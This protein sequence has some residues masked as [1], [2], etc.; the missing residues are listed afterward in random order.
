MEAW[1]RHN[2][3]RR[4]AEQRL[5]LQTAL[6]NTL[7]CAALCKSGND[8]IYSDNVGSYRTKVC[9]SQNYPKYTVTF[10]LVCIMCLFVVKRDC[11]VNKFF[12]FK[13]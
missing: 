9:H 13:Q 11:I 4:P 6:K 1:K 10:E 5:L 7:D 8:N 12:H 2:Q 3:A